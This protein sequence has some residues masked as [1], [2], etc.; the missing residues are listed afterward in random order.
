MQRIFVPVRIN[1]EF[2]ERT[3]D[4]ETNSRGRTERRCRQDGRV[5]RIKN[6]SKNSVWSRKKLKNFLEQNG[7]YQ[8]QDAHDTPEQ[9]LTYRI[10]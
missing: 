6:T 1:A 2:D 10:R 3:C 8:P 4:D 9:G 7:A 5:I